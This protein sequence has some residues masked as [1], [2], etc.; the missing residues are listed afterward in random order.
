MWCCPHCFTQHED[1]V[2]GCSRCGRGNPALALMRVARLL[3][4]LVYASVLA[5]IALTLALVV[6]SNNPYAGFLALFAPAWFVPTWIGTLAAVGTSVRGLQAIPRPR[7]RRDI[8]TLVLAAVALIG[9]TG[10]PVWILLS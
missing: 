5:A 8:I 9:L 6:F 7:L 2:E 3:T 10:L 1:R 4:L